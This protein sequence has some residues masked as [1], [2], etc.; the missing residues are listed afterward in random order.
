M[1]EIPLPPLPE[2]DALEEDYVKLRN[3]YKEAIDRKDRIIEELRKENLLL[4]R[5][6][7]KTSERLAEMQG[8]RDTSLS[9]DLE[10]VRIQKEIPSHQDT[11]KDAPVDSVRQPKDL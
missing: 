9:K 3:W 7:L 1:D 2:N 4:V 5:S 11:R 10:K 8:L 6:S